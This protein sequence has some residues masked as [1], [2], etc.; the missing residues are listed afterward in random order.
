MAIPLRKKKAPKSKGKKHKTPT[1]DPGPDIEVLDVFKTTLEGD[2]GS[3]S[4]ELEHQLSDLSKA[5]LSR[6][7]RKIERIRGSSLKNQKLLEKKKKR[8]KAAISKKV[9]RS[10]QQ[11]VRLVIR[12]ETHLRRMKGCKMIGK[13]IYCKEQSFSLRR[14]CETYFLKEILQYNSR[15]SQG[16]IIPDRQG[17]TGGGFVRRVVRNFLTEE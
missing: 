14:F 4:E 12:I 2:A 1:F 16:K 6:L 15:V 11:E 3:E 13:R 9:K 10:Q 7:E 17:L 5:K 8:V